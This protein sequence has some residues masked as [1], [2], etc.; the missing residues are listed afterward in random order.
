MS[1]TL[2]RP[3]ME[4]TPPPGWTRIDTLDTHAEGEPLRIIQ[5]GVPGGFPAIPGG[6]ILEKRRHAKEHLDGLRTA[7]MLEPRGHDDMYGCLLTDP[8]TADGDL[9]VLFTHNEGYSTMCGHGVIALTTAVFETGMKRADGPSPMLR[10]DTPA[11]RVTATADWDA[12]ARRVRRVSFENV[13]AYVAVP[14]LTV[15]VDGIGDVTGAIAY[16]GAYYV[17]VDAEPL[18]LRLDADAPALIDAGMRIKRAVTA[19]QTLEHPYDPDLAFL[20]GTILCGPPH[21]PGANS[22]NVCIFADGEVDRSP[23]GTGVSGR[24]A[25]ERAA[26]RLPLGQPFTVESILGTRFTG[27]ALRDT[28]FGP[29]DAVIPEISGRA[30]ITGRHQFVIAPDDPLSAGFRIG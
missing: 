6:T 4:W 22:R 3:R 24:V 14:E 20:Y 29:H 2:I 15:F 25:I 21:G 26:G 18:G 16:G 5:T 7:L 30:W 28:A 9:G 13:A 1:S 27:R 8:V 10:L 19:A 11:G 12:A 23:T 17:Y